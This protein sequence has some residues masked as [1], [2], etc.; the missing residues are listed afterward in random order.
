MDT[1]DEEEKEVRCAWCDKVI[2]DGEGIYHPIYHHLNGHVYCNE[3][4]A[5]GYLSTK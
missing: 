4:C 3:N 2:K 1:P 5:N